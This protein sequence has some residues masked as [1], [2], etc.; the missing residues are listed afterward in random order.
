M[1]YLSHVSHVRQPCFCYYSPTRRFRGCVWCVWRVCVCDMKLRLSWMS[2]IDTWSWKLTPFSFFLM[3]L[4]TTLWSVKDIQTSRVTK[5]MV[6]TTI[7]IC[8]AVSLVQV[9]F[10]YHAWILSVVH[11]PPPPKKK[12]PCHGYSK[13]QAAQR[14]IVLAIKTCKIKS[15]ETR[16]IL[17]ISYSLLPNN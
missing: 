7:E 1:K 3:L 9:W 16:K 6:W 12:K 5:S 2:S 10:S 4:R 15:W 17:V 8:Q 14:V 13:R 11:S